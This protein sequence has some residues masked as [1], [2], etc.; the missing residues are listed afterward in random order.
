MIGTA[1]AVGA[2]TILNAIAS[3]KG[4]TVAVDLPTEATAHITRAK[5][6]WTSRINGKPTGSPLAELTA[7][8]AI[9]TM[10]K[11][12][13]DYSG[14]VETS[15]S[16]PIG[17][18][19]KTSSSSS[20]A[21]AL[22]TCAALGEESPDSADILR[23]SVNSSLAAKV[24]VTGALDDA[25]SCLLGGANFTDNRSIR[26]LSTNKLG[27]ALSVL[28]R[29]P[30]ARSRRSSVAKSYTERFSSL[31]DWLFAVG[32]DGQLW[33]AMT[34]NGMLYSAIYGYDP[35]QALAAVEHGALGAGLSGTG[36]A[37]AAV[38]EDRAALEEVASAWGVDGAQVIET[39][40]TD[41]GARIGL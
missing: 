34:L 1:R 28:I 39:R 38:F 22:A 23:C 27:K 13:E 41:E 6:R 35:S 30:E 7:K 33:K 18:G 17:V 11:D 29:I 2:I 4:A 12:P 14:S 37:M 36:P 3:G 26:L 10:G 25:S 5:G 19:L 21:V 15:T 24:S 9:R 16:V 40:T 20:I 31:A 8:E 32:A